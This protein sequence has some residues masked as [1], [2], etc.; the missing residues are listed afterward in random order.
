MYEAAFYYGERADQQG[1]ILYTLGL[2]SKRYILATVHRQENTDDP[3]HKN[4]R[5]TKENV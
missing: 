5:R 3:L 1:R 2:E 4:S